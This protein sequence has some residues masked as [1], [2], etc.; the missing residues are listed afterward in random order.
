MAC[1][2]NTGGARTGGLLVDGGLT[3]SVQQAAGTVALQPGTISCGQPSVAVGSAPGPIT[4]TAV[5]GG[6]SY[7]WE[8]RT[9]GAWA[10]VPGVTSQSYSPGALYA[11][12]SYRRVVT[13]GGATA[14]SNAVTVEVILP[15]SANQNY[16]RSYAPTE[17]V[18]DAE[19]LQRLPLAQQGLAV[20]YYDGLGRP[21]QAVAVAASPTDHYDPM[22]YDA[23]GR[24]HRKYLP[25]AASGTAGAYR[26]HDLS[27]EA[28]YRATAQYAYYKRTGGGNTNADAPDSDYPYAET[29]FEA[30]P[31]G[32]VLEQG[33]PGEAW[34]PVRSGAAESGHTVRMAYGTNAAGDVPRWG[35]SA[36]GDLIPQGTYP[37]GA[38]SRTTTRDEGWTAA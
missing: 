38:L 29:V 25:Y 15:G 6:A 31:L 33:A 28:K 32:R 10:A 27:T 26:P 14:Y 36:T 12:T 2:A 7:R 34:Q 17:R 21:L 30:S 22:G 20:Q 13:L 35:V 1:A 24:E 11:T 23:L 37:A 3:V 4:G 18:A 8:R 16:I 5:A 19:A 9:D